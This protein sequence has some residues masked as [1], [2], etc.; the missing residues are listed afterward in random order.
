[1]L[2]ATVQIL[3]NFTGCSTDDLL[4]S[5][6]PTQDPT[7]YLRPGSHVVLTY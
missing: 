3:L 2:S 4:L 7:L 5:Q 1:M 6:D